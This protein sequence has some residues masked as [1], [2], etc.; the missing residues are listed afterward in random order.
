MDESDPLGI[1]LLIDMFALF[2]RE[3]QFII[4]LYELHYESKSLDLLPNFSWSIALSYFQKYTTLKEEKVLD[5]L[6]SLLSLS[7]NLIY[8]YRKM[9]KLMNLVSF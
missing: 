6:I 1:M 8:F 2:S 9:M 3:N 7:S 5:V 4:D